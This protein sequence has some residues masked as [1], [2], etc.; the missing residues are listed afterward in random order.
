MLKVLEVQEIE[1]TLMEILCAGL[2]EQK[3]EV[4]PQLQFLMQILFHQNGI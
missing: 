1:L 4:L 3:P 2:V